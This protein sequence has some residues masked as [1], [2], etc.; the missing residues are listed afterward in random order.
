MK[1][2]IKKISISLA[3]LMMLG[4]YGCQSQSKKVEHVNADIFE[5]K[6]NTSKDFILLDVRTAPEYKQAHLP[7]A[8]MLDYYQK[9]FKQELEKL[10]KSKPVFVYCTV[11]SRSSS[12]ANLMNEMGFT[13]VYNLQGGI[14][15]WAESKKPLEK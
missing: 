3:L 5:S 10:D 8:I 11:G 13:E 7:G 9:N 2:L 15:H 4:V 12:A 6:M 1:H 14:Y